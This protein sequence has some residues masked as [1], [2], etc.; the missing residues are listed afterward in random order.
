MALVLGQILLALQRI[1]M[2]KIT[3]AVFGGAGLLYGL[4]A[5][6]LVFRDAPIDLQVIMIAGLAAIGA[7]AGWLVGLAASLLVR[8]SRMDRTD[9]A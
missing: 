8:K 2:K 3:T 1:K 4:F 6:L 9:P 7:C 5:V